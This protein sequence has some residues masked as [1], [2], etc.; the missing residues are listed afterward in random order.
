MV[1]GLVFSIS[2]YITMSVLIKSKETNAP[3][4]TNYSISQA[5]AIA[6]NQFIK[7]K[8]VR[9]TY[10]SSYKPLTV[11]DQFPSAG[12]RIKANSVIKVYIS[13]EI[14]EISVPDFSG[15]SL[16]DSLDL[17]RES[18]LKQGYIS[19]I[20]AQDV[21]IGFIVSQSLPAGTTVYKGVPIN[22]LTSKGA[23][24]TS[25]MMPDLIMKN[26]AQVLFY[27]EAVGFSVAQLEYDDY[28]G[29]GPGIVLEQYP[30]P[31]FDLNSKTRIRLVVSK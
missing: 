22:L 25:Y 4:L 26:A 15:I 9:G 7:L 10:D 29:L 28:P 16:N 21:P 14:E 1:Y 13:S 18:G 3:D 5:R 30:K 6:K 19:Y 17:I 8:E 12:T 23:K 2:V 11:V 24:L 31:G 27:F 20:H